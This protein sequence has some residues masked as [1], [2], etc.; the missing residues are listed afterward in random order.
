ME[1]DEV[2]CIPTKLCSEIASAK[3][4]YESN[5]IHSNELLLV[6]TQRSQISIHPENRIHQ[7]PWQMTKYDLSGTKRFLFQAQHS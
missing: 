7:S 5:V 1:H 4:E 6:Q 3:V 2:M